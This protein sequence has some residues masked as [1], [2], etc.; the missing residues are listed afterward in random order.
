MPSDLERIIVAG[1]RDFDDPSHF[2]L[3]M[4][5]VRSQSQH[6]YVV[7]SGGA[8][9]VDALGERWAHER[10]CPMMPFDV[11][12]EHRDEWGDFAYPRRNEAMAEYADTLVAFF[13]GDKD[14]GTWDMIERAFDHGLEVHVYPVEVNDA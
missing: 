1:H 7:V 5:C 14:T 4:S 12:E 10:S 2:S 11:T 3:K 13:N 6:K 8:R 9:G